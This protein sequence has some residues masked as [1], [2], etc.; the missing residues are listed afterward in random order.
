MKDTSGVSVVI[1][2]ARNKPSTAENLLSVIAALDRFEGSKELIMVADRK[3]DTDD[4]L[5]ALVAKR[6][7]IKLL[8]T[9]GERGSAHARLIAIQASQYEVILFTDDDCVVPQN[10]ILH[11][12]QEVVRRGIV[13]GNLLAS[14]PTNILGSVDAYIDRLRMRTRDNDGNAKYLSFPNFGIRRGFIP[15]SP[16]SAHQN[17]TVEDIELACQ[18]RLAGM[19][20]HFDENI[21]VVTDY[22]ATFTQL[23]KRKKKHAKGIAFL[24]YRLGENHCKHIS[25]DESPWLMFLRWAKLSLEAPLT[26][27]QKLY[28]FLANVAYCTALSYYDR[29]F[30]NQNTERR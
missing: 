12:Q 14:Q 15:K 17:N 26:P 9:G 2:T 6:P 23:I 30:H 1:P 20:I 5:L 7:F 8:E 21:A 25:L 29:K 3:T 11:M 24:R 28:M 16:F 4:F 13:A 10:W 27:T 19:S 18:L 22:P